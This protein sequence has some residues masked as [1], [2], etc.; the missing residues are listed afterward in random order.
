M[1]TTNSYAVRE[2]AK[3]AIAK[4]ADRYDIFIGDNEHLARWTIDRQRAVNIIEKYNI[5]WD[6]SEEYFDKYV[7]TYSTYRDL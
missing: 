5:T 2:H 3:L 6:M 4:I 7:S 1:N